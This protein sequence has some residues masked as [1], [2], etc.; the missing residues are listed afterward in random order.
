ME[1]RTIAH[2]RGEPAGSL[3]IKTGGVAVEPQE[4]TT[5]RCLTIEQPWAW[6][7]F[8]G[9]TIETR[10]QL[11]T[12]YRGPVAIHASARWSD[13]GGLSDLI[14][15]AWK[16]ATTHCTTAE[17]GHTSRLWTARGEIVGLADLVDVHE[18]ACGGCCRPWSEAG[19][20]ERS[21]GKRR[22]HLV[23]ENPRALAQPIW[24]K[25]APGLWVPPADI[26]QRIN[27]FDS[28]SAMGP[29]RLSA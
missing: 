11:R 16:K 3:E 10:A 7:I 22:T 28:S 19:D 21:G 25:G 6:A 4:S 24:C 17:Y 9:R 20:V 14:N 12:T 2:Q 18:E 13:R 26:A 23:L 8:H 5:L 27:A 15:G 1:P 29:N